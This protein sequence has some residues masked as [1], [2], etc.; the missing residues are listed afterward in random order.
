[1][2]IELQVPIEAWWVFGWWVIGGMRWAGVAAMFIVIMH[3][4][5]RM[6]EI[7]EAKK[8]R[9][10]QQRKERLNRDD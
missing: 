5:T 8:L 3:V 4:L 1:M 9:E 10:Q 6:I 7:N 2:K